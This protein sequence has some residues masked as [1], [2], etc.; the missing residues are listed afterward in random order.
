MNKKEATL[1]TIKMHK[2]FLR[3]EIIKRGKL[4]PNADFHRKEIKKYEEILKNERL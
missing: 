1:H 4:S 3:K 2:E